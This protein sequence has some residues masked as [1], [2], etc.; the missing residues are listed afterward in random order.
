MW[1]LDASGGDWNFDG[2]GQGKVLT[3]SSVLS[4]LF[5]ECLCTLE[6]QDDMNPSYGSNLEILAGSSS[7]Q[8]EIQ[9]S[10]R[11]AV[12]QEVARLQAAYKRNPSAFLP[13]QVPLSF[14]AVSSAPHQWEVIVDTLGGAQSF[15]FSTGEAAQ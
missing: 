3:G 13:T 12:A 5:S 7:S 11:S 1:T 8:G 15:A 4:Q 6:G 2:T 9:S 14:V 10:I